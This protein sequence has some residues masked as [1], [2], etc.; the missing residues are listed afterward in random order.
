MKFVIALFLAF[1]FVPVSASACGAE[2]DCTLSDRTYRIQMPDTP[3]TETRSALIF[4]H[5]YKGSA[6]GTMRNKSLQSLAS[7]LGAALVAPDAIMDD[8]S[9]PGAPQQSTSQ[10]VDELAYFD[11]LKDALVSR[12]GID[13]D[14]I[15]MAGFSAGGMMVWNLACHRPE[16]F[17][18]F[19]PVA[20]TFWRPVPDGCE[21]PTA[22]L[23]HIHGT[24]DKI[25]PLRGRPIAETHQ[26]D[27]NKA[28]AMYASSGGYSLGEAP[29]INPALTCEAWRNSEDALL[30]KCLHE[31]GHSF[32][33]EYL[34]SAWNLLMD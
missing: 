22:N 12:H 21:T 7:R 16:A 1:W 34:E 26:G 23:I 13:P 28:L 25:V 18:G 8:W 31:G 29:D 20:G 30:M 11:A 3:G 17:A 24:A 10:E 2:T 15:I 14:R 33:S 6:R 19:I 9:L 32:K 27:V 4:A 5:G